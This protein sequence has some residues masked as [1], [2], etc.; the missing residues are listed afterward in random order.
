MRTRT[1]QTVDSKGQLMQDKGADGTG[2]PKHD[3]RAPSVEPAGVFRRR[4]RRW[5][6]V[7]PPKIP[8]STP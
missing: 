6:A 1:G 5:R 8:A 2:C 3:R 4:S 7:R